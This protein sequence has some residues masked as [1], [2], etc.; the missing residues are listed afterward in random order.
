LLRGPVSLAFL[1]TASLDILEIVGH[2]LVHGLIDERIDERG[3]QAEDG[4]INPAKGP[5]CRDELFVS[6]HGGSCN[7]F[8]DGLNG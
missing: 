5:R 1:A 8:G 7:D 2:A 4:Q 6:N 3:Q